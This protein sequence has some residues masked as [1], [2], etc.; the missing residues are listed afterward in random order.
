[1][2]G[3]STLYGY[4]AVI[5]DVQVT[6][7]DGTAANLAQKAFPVSNF[8]ACGFAGSVQIGYAM[9]ERLR[10]C[11]AIPAHL[12]DTK[13]WDPPYVA[14]RFSGEARALFA[15]APKE[16]RALGCALLM[17]GASPKE[18]LGVGAR[19][20]LM[21]L[22]SPDFAPSISGRAIQVRSIGNG[23]RVRAY[24]QSIKSLMRPT[25]GIRQGEIGA[26]GGWAQALSMAINLRV[27]K[28]PA[29]GVSAGHHLL[30]VRRGEISGEYVEMPVVGS[31]DDND[32]MPELAGSY[33]EFSALCLQRSLQSAGASC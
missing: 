9:I 32:V 7:A 21:R 18:P 16:E 31:V 24:K 22:A 4:G 20:F 33:S 2:I 6:F 11:L 13:A 29:V 27:Q 25:S 17:V 1:M 19:I 3:A 28:E 14:K 12:A 10:R 23:A 26:P 30:I 15:A 8:I 5:S